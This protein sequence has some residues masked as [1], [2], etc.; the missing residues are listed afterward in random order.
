MKP[1]ALLT[2]LCALAATVLLVYVWP[3]TQQVQQLELD[4][5]EALNIKYGLLSIDEWKERS[6][7]FIS[8]QVE[9]FQL[10]ISDTASVKEQTERLLLVLIDE[11]QR[12]VEDNS[13]QNWA[14]ASLRG[15]VQGLVL[16]FDQLRE[17]IPNV[18]QS[19]LAE[20]S[21]MIGEYSLKK[22]ALHQLGQ[23]LDL[24]APRQDEGIRQYFQS[25][26]ACAELADCGRELS[27]E[28]VKKERSI[29]RLK[30]VF[31]LLFVLPLVFYLLSYKTD[32]SRFTL[33]AATILSAVFLI[34]GLFFPMIAIDAR[35]E[36]LQF[37][38]LG[39]QVDFGE[40]V[41]FYQ[42]KSIL[43]VT[44][45]LISNGNFDTFL[46]GCLVAIFSIVFPTAKL[47]ATLFVRPGRTSPF[48]EFL[49]TK[50]S[51]WSMA[52]VFVVAIF[53]SF[54]GLR[55]MVGSQMDQLSRGN[56]QLD[57]VATDYT[58]LKLGF[59]LFLLF[60]LASLWVS[61]LLERRLKV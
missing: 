25:Q 19:L 41:L 35:V 18:S 15:F 29:N 20:A 2:S 60:C 51:K 27:T 42:S 58:A 26:Y 21:G 40:Q 4:R 38:L 11:A 49:T 3:L 24:S 13:D 55:G 1:L 61:H 44:G 22:L 23:L 31:C 10:D 39:G 32:P 57:L 54:I 17:E 7:A 46:V 59:L 33:V 45:L 14:M 36:N 6:F 30:P 48:W 28:I 8:E 9:S 47:L 52:D 16:D 5:A 34:G 56:T 53:M 43:Q 37:E 12:V 50:A